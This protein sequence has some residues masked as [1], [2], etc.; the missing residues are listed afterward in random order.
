LDESAAFYNAA[1]IKKQLLGNQQSDAKLLIYFEDYI[2]RNLKNNAWSK[3]TRRLYSNTYNY[4]ECFLSK[5]GAKRI[6]LNQFDLILIGKLDDY[7]KQVVWNELGA[8]LSV[9]S[10]NKHHARLKAVLNDA[11]SRGEL[12]NKHYTK[13]KLN[14]PPSNREYLTKDE[15]AKINSL[16]LCTNKTLDAVRDIFMFSCYTGLR[17]CDA[18]ELSLEN[19][20]IINDEQHI[21]VDQIKTN[22][23]REIPLLT[24]ALRIL[25]KYSSA[26]FRLIKHKI[27]PSYSNQR[28][29]IYL[30][31]IAA[32]AGISKNLTHHI[33][34][35]TC[36]TTILLDNNVPIEVVSH[37]LGH[38]NIRTTQIYAKISHTKLQTQSG[39]LNR[40]LNIDN[41]N[42]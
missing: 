19:I 8:R 30:K 29:N 3:A 16:D 34:R 23:R 41:F 39:R 9:S 36:A 5:H 13:F 18:M 33:A 28:V 40:I 15:L 22:E 2:Q 31:V 27:L 4:L 21:R 11:I 24:P 32:Q 26:H 10:I 12:V 17:F 38:T 1:D 6:T 7:L 42:I 14:F 25:N 20:M 35:H 37:W